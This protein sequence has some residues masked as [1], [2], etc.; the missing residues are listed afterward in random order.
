[1]PPDSVGTNQIRDDAVTSPKVRNGTLLP[2]DFRAGQLQPR[3]YAAVTPE[4]EF[5]PQR[6]KG[7]LD[8]V[9]AEGT[10][11]VYCFDLESTPKHAVASPFLTNSAVVGTAVAGNANVNSLCPAG[12]EDAAAKTFGSSA[13]DDAP[14]NF[15]IVFF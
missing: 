8:V 4:G 6:S 11:N 5:N 14:I 13:A 15:S 9:I 2:A 7:V 1:M 10:T 3:A 12:A